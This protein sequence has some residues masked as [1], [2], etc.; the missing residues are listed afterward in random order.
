MANSRKE[1]RAVQDRLEYVERRE[2]ERE[3]DL[4][5]QLKSMQIELSQMRGN[6]TSTENECRQEMSR[7]Q[8]EW[9]KATAAAKEAQKKA[10]N[11]WRDLILEERERLAT[12][13]QQRERERFDSL[14]H[15]VESLADELARLSDIVAAN[16][17]GNSRLSSHV[18]QELERHRS[19]LKRHKREESE[20]LNLFEETCTQLQDALRHERR[21]REESMNRIEKLLT[22]RGVDSATAPVS[23]LHR[24]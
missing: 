4:Y 22:R 7:L 24:F 14:H 11:I 23:D 12:E 2:K 15:V 5:G 8:R 6:F 18:E 21:A 19:W 17:T 1:L 3:Q 9:Q 13:H 20:F 16:R 10:E